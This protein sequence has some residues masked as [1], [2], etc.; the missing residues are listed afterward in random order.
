MKAE[1]LFIWSIFTT[2]L[3]FQNVVA[4]MYFSCSSKAEDD[5]T[6]EGLWNDQI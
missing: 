4:Y 2:C 1:L 6:S 5:S 3:L